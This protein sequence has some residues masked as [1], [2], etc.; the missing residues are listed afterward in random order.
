[1]LNRRQ[2]RIK[3]LQALYA[4]QQSHNNSIAVGEKEL[5]HSIDRVFDL[6]FYMLSLLVEV[7]AV[8]E[9]KI[10]EAKNKH[11]PTER[12]LNPNTKF[13]NNL[14]LNTIEGNIQYIDNVESRKSNWSDQIDYVRS[15]FKRFSESECYINYMNTEENNLK[16]DKDL[17]TDLFSEF[18]FDSEDIESI[19]EE[20]SIYWAS[21]LDLVGSFIL[22]TVSMMKKTATEAT[23][24]LKNVSFRNGIVFEDREFV[25]DLFRKSINYDKD[26]EEL[27][28]KQTKN[29]EMDRIALLDM[30]LMKMALCEIMYFNSI[31]V[32]VTLNE[33]IELSKYFS[34]PKS[35]VFINGILDKIIVILKETDRIKKTG[36]GL[37][38][39]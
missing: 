29:W 28:K 2:L 14:V 39:S 16:E 34:T 22:K 12:D 35:R 4:F 32:K 9:R 3:T 31:P 24:L 7:K 36:R 30:L 17:V 6:Y 18:I 8:A 1:M 11:L 27:I 23:P 15:L 19:L 33:Y 21:D 26:F 37:I 20:K 25:V 38:D 10:E 13:I 5:T